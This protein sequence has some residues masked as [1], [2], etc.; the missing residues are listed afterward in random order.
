MRFHKNN[1]KYFRTFID[2]PKLSS[3]IYLNE[4]DSIL[5]KYSTAKNFPAEDIYI[6]HHEE[7]LVNSLWLNFRME[8]F[9]GST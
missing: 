2:T 4:K 9:P 8:R 5:N 3:C 1:D 7:K 6:L